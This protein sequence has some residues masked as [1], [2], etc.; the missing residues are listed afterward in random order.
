MKWNHVITKRHHIIKTL[1][2]ISWCYHDNMITLS[3]YQDTTLVINILI[4]NYTPS[5]KYYILN[6]FF[7]LF[8]CNVLVHTVVTV[9]TIFPYQQNVGKIFARRQHWLMH[10]LTV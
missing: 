7:E 8:I 3:Q 9:W 2:Y 1:L 5:D 10:S 6:F 4:E